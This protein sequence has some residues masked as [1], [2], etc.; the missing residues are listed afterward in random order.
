M[1]W[2]KTLLSNLMVSPSWAAAISPR[3]DPSPPSLVFVTVSV[4]GNALPSSTSSRGW[5]RYGWYLRA[6]MAS[7][8]IVG[9]S[10]FGASAS[11]ASELEFAR[12]KVVEEISKAAG[13]K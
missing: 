10:V 6:T 11:N 2:P 13:K 8:K 1:V 12:D 9:D 7:E 4:L 3:R 5:K